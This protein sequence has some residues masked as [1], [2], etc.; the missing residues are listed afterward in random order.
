MS[1]NKPTN[2]HW[3]PKSYLRYFATPN[4]IGTDNPQVICFPKNEGAEFPTSTRNACGKRYLYS[5]K[6]SDG[7]RIWDL[8]ESLCDV[9]GMAS[10]IW[11]VL[12]SDFVD[13]S[14]RHLRMAVS[15]YVATMYYRNISIREQVESL[16]CQIVESVS[17]RKSGTNENFP[18]WMEINGVRYNLSKDEFEKYARWGKND[19]DHFFAHF[20]RD[21]SGNMAQAILK[22]RWSI[23]FAE[24]DAFITSDRP[25]TMVHQEKEKFGYLTAGTIVYFPLSPR[26]LLVIDDLYDQPNNQYYPLNQDGPGGINLLIFRNCQRFF[27]TGRQIEYVLQEICDFSDRIENNGNLS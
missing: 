1:E 25:V 15:L 3:V 21:N 2:Q 27:V 6:D 9:E 24:V 10:T 11:P 4:S 12:A 22:K 16:H 20:V 23:I 14:D 19:H 18:E 26:R 5:P 7:N 17:R 8:E 13:L